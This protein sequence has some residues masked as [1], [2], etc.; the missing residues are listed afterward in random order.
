[1][2]QL[3]QVPCHFPERSTGSAALSLELNPPRTHKTESTLTN[4]MRRGIVK[5]LNGGQTGN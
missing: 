4:R 1:V 2:V 3:V 5:Y